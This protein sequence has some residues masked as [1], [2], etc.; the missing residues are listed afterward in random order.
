MTPT[1]RWVHSSLVSS[2]NPIE[3]FVDDLITNSLAKDLVH[4]T[5]PHNCSLIFRA[6]R[7]VPVMTA[8]ARRPRHA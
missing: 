7:V 1:S 2:A 6:N 8:Q 5:F 3:G 4:K